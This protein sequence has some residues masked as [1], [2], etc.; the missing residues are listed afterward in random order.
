MKGSRQPD[1]IRYRECLE[2]LVRGY[3][4]KIVVALATEDPEASMHML[5][6]NDY[7][8]KTY[9]LQAVHDELLL[10]HKMAQEYGHEFQ[11]KQLR[12]KL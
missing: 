3:S 5:A 2:Q 9:L 8:L 1:V 6:N 4:R 10:A 12:S 11:Y 7:Q